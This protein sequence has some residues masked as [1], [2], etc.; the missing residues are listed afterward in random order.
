ML[1]QILKKIFPK[2][3]NLIIRNEIK[4][5]SIEDSI[6][7]S[8][9]QKINKIEENINTIISKVEI[10]KLNSISDI[11]YPKYIDKELKSDTEKLN[12]VKYKDKYF[13]NHIYLFKYEGMVRKKIIE[14]KF[15]EKSY[16]NETFVN[17]ILKNEKICRFLKS[18]DIITPVPIHIKRKRK[19]G[20]NQSEIIAKKVAKNIEN[21]QYIPNCL[22]KQKNTVAQSSLTKR[23]RIK[24]VKGVYKLQNEQML[25]NKS[26]VIFDDIYTTGSTVNECAKLLREANVKKILVLTLAKD[27]LLKT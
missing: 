5:D 20:Y 9:D 3:Q 14:Y 19:R 2:M 16:L 18:Y 22:V 21:L 23:Q 27:F 25:S 13:D 11:F 17:F 1:V 6:I 8:L 4:E 26:V 15:K 24:N 7:N 12:I 10:P